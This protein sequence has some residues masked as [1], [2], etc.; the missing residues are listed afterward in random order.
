MSALGDY[1]HY[2]ASNYAKY[3]VAYPREGSEHYG[4]GVLEGYL[5]A[6][7]QSAR[8]LKL[9]AL[10]NELLKNTINVIQQD[11]QSL[12][13]DYGRKI[14]QFK[15]IAMAKVSDKNKDYTDNLVNKTPN[16]LTKAQEKFNQIQAHINKINTNLLEGRTTSQY[17]IDE[18]TKL[19]KSAGAGR[20][21]SILGNIQ[22]GWND[23]SAKTW[24][25]TLD[26]SVGQVMKD[27][28][29]VSAEKVVREG[30]KQ[31]LIGIP[32]IKVE[33]GA[34]ANQHPTYQTSDDTGS[35]YAID[36]TSNG[37]I[38]NFSPKRE[39]ILS[40]SITNIYAN[41]VPFGL[42]VLSGE[43][44]LGSILA[45]IE[46][47]NRFGTHWLNLHSNQLDSSL[48][49]EL[50]PI[51]VHE[52]LKSETEQYG[53]FIHIDRTI[54]QI[55]SRDYWS[56]INDEKFNISPNISNQRFS[57]TW[58]GSDRPNREDAYMRV[59]NILGQMHSINLQIASRPI[60]I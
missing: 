10:R 40:G 55:E 54:G 48:D 32:G 37:W 21:T 52:A 42:F 49:N 50:E 6:H 24:K 27:F 15:S 14:N 53:S 60:V 25:K 30:L 28:T 29:Q 43:V 11:Q 26:N 9:E 39:N 31:A 18:L 35:T 1:I 38:F 20:R 51:I 41:D 5:R 59:N 22:Q 23:Y 44:N 57:N 34:A 8:P 13:L 12:N 17:E 4:G 16:Q 19:Y 47:E 3:G 56:I 46:G 2:R 33:V 58:V 36:A 45:M 7:K